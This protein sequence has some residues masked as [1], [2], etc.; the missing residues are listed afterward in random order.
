MT[1]STAPAT[2]SAALT[3]YPSIDELSKRGKLTRA[4]TFSAKMRPPASNNRSSSVSN[5][6]TA[7]RIELSAS[8]SVS[9]ESAPQCH[10]YWGSRQT[11][12][13]MPGENRDHCP[14]QLVWRARSYNR[15]ARRGDLC[16]EAQG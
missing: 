6:R 14:W 13:E 5:G 10:R 9:M 7:A 11:D 12:V 1:R 4:N 3:A 15:G 2:A 16:I 8:C